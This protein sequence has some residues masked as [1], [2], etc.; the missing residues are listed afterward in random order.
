MRG[1]RTEHCPSAYHTVD[2][3]EDTDTLKEQDK[4]GPKEHSIS[5]C[6]Q[7]ANTRSI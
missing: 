6:Q 4:R 2:T 5:V 3:A 7:L 1:I